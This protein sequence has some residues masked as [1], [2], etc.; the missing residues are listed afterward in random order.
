MIQRHSCR[1]QSGRPGTQP[2]LPQH[3]N[4]GLHKICQKIQAPSKPIN[5]H[6]LYKNTTWVPLYFLGLKNCTMQPLYIMLPCDPLKKKFSP[7]LICLKLY[8]VNIYRRFKLILSIEFSQEK[9]VACYVETQVI[10]ELQVD[11]GTWGN[12]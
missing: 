1:R 9:L 12:P 11:I 5:Q 6:K 3:I 7:T 2:P 8:Q 4:I 10:R